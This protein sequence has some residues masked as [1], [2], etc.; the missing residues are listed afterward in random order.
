MPAMFEKI[1]KIKPAYDMTYKCVLFLCKV[2]LVVDILITSMAVAG[3]YIPF[4]PDPAWSEEVVL[5]CM[6]YMAVLSAALAIR[7][8]AHIR[9][10]AF[11][12]YLPSNLVK[13]LDILADLAVF[14]LAIIMIT[15]GWKYATGIGS[16]GTY[17]SMPKVSRFWMYFPVPLAGAAMFVFEIE[18]IYNHIKGFFVKEGME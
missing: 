5:T 7:R 16:K 13:S 11:D 10:T 17:V 18:A 3:R 15:V 14:A 2:L 6:S 12:R 4:I 1:D 8:G 9:M